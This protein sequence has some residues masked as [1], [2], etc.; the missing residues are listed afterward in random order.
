MMKSIKCCWNTLT[1]KKDM[2]EYLAE[3]NDLRVGTKER[4]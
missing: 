4:T 2:D 1:M 3:L